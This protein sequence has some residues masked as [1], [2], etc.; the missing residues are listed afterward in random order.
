MPPRNRP[1]TDQ[2]F[3]GLQRRASEAREREIPPDAEAGNASQGRG[4]RAVLRTQQEIEHD[5]RSLSEQEREDIL[6]STHLVTDL[7]DLRDQ[8]RYV[9]INSVSPNPAQPRKSFDP[10]QMEELVESVRTHGVMSPIHVQAL[11]DGKY[12]IIA[13]ERRWRAARRAGRTNIPV[14]VKAV[15]DAQALEMALLENLHRADLSA[16]E[17]SRTYRFMMDQFHY[18][19]VQLAE[20][21]GKRQAYISKMLA[22]L[23]LP[24]AIQT[25]MG[26]VES[27]ENIPHGIS[28]EGITS[29]TLLSAGAAMVLS[30]VL[31]P[32]VQLQL[33]Q[34]VIEEGLSVRAVE[35]L[36]RDWK[37]GNLSTAVAE[38]TVYL[39]AEPEQI[40]EAEEPVPA[41]RR[42]PTVY[43]TSFARP[44]PAGP[45]IRFNDLSLFQLHREVGRI[46]TVDLARLEDALTSDLALIRVIQANAEATAQVGDAPPAADH[47]RPNEGREKPSRR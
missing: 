31:D 43:P 27:G 40:Q 45:Q 22:L 30:R 38:P 26:E 7:A 11:P 23:E 14:I 36:V 13:G 2:L 8:I 21:I 4:R 37:L 18:T 9:D 34:R 6:S 5:L 35:T 33:A 15:D 29:R 25:L 16:L 41:R 3:P 28:G 47:E 46:A 19:Q 24:A 20:R 1:S 17:E 10:Q 39:E 44:E 32:E 42:T 12:R